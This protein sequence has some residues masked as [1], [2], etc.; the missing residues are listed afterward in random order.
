MKCTRL[1]LGMA[2]GACAALISAKVSA[3]SAI[4]IRMWPD[5]RPTRVTIDYDA[6]TVTWGDNS[7]AARITAQEVYWEIPGESSF[8]FNRHSS[9]IRITGWGGLRNSTNLYPCTTSTQ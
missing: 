8:S 3:E 1:M 7:A 4:L 6:R 5:G 2:I 9:K